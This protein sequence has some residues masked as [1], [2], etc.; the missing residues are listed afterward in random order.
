MAANNDY[1][2]SFHNQWHPE[3]PLPPVPSPAFDQPDQ[4][5]TILSSVSSPYGDSLNRGYGRR[6]DQSLGSNS[7]Y[8]GVGGGGPDHEPNHYADDIPLRQHPSKGTAEPLSPDYGRY[9]PASI[10]NMPHAGHQPVQARRKKRWF[11]GRVPWV[12]YTFTIIQI[13][14]FIAALVRNGMQAPDPSQPNYTDTPS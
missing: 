10:N 4:H 12:T 2:S 5:P 11:G 9:E 7:A 14:V 8:Y 13:T 1:Q 6:S 3:A